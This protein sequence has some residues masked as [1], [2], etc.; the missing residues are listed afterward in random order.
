MDR[1]Q[2]QQLDN[3][4]NVTI[5]IPPQAQLNVSFAKRS[6]AYANILL[7]LNTKAKNISDVGSHSRHSQH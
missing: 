5:R 6:Y 2:Q 1:R 3:F 7:V 4:C